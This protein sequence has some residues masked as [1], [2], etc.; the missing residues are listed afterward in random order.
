M[1]NYKEKEMS[2]GWI[3]LYRDIVK[4]WIWQDPVKLKWWLDILLTV[5]RED[6]KVNIGM[7]L[8]DCKRGQSVMSL[9]NWGKRWGVSKDR[10][11]SFFELLKNDTMITTENLSKTTR[12]TVCNYEAYQDK[13][14]DDSP[15]AHY[16]PDDGSPQAHPNN[17]EEQY[18]NDNKE[19]NIKG[20]FEIF[21]NSYHQITG[22]PKT[23]KD[24]AFKYYKT[25]NKSEKKKALDSIQ[26][27][28][29][30]QDDKKYIKKCRTYL[31]DKNFND[32][33]KVSPNKNVGKVFY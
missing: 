24:N 20:E 26:D 14:D 8:I 5:N 19:N 11:R 16:E 13:P 28:Y 31:S 15:Q 3:C 30:S 22:K 9:K 18:N 23:D 2:G 33:F 32:E 10:V 27:Y 12:I 7:M 6:K 25:L 21:W 4:H 29:N 1:Y 17:N